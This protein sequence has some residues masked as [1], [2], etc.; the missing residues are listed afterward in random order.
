MT[1]F[2]PRRLATAL[3][4]ALTLVSC[5]TANN[6]ARAD[7]LRP[8][9]YPLVACDPYF[10]VWSFTDQLAE[11]F[12]VH[13][14]GQI[15][16]LTSFVRIDG[17]KLR[18]MGN[19]VEYYRS[20]RSMRQ[21]NVE[22]RATNTTYT[23]EEFGVE[24]KLQF[25]NPN[26]PDDLMIMS[27]PATYVTWTARSTDGANHEVKVYFDATAEL[28]VNTVD[29]KVVAKR[30]A[31]DNLDV[32]RLGTEAQETLVKSGDYMRVDYG[33]FY[34]AAEKGV[35]KNVIAGA[36]KARGVFLKSGDLP[37]A[38]DARFPRRAD[39]DWPVVAFT[40]DCG[41]VGK[42]AVSKRVIL[43]YDDVWA[44]TWLGEKIRPYWRKDGQNALG[45]L[46]EAN[47]QYDDLCKRCA[48]FDA[49]L[50][51]R[52][53]AKGGVK[54]AELCSLAYP[55]AIA[56]HKLAVMPNG[57]TILIS[58]ENSSNGC[59][60]TVDILYPTA[61]IFAATN[62]EL[63]KATTTPVL[64]Y[65]GKSGRW[66]H[67][68]A[69]HD[70]GQYPL[71]DGQRYGG[72]ERTEENQMPVEESA[73][74]IIIVDLIARIENSADYAAEYWDTLEKWAQYLLSKGLDPENQLCT[75]DFAGHLAHNANLSAKAIVALAC[76]SDLCQRAGKEDAAKEYRAKAEE[77]VKEWM[78]LADNG[79][80]YRLAFDRPDTWSMKYNIVW[81]R[82]MDLKLFPK[83]VVDKELAYYKKVQNKFG[84]PLDNR[85]DYT[86]TDWEVWVASMADTREGFDSVME[87]IYRS[88]NATPDRVPLTDWYYTSTAK[89]QAFRA[90]AVVGGIFM[91]LLEPDEK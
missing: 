83:E 68:F 54:Y 79:D 70:I 8:P 52:A 85:S 31:T 33:Y 2:S 10:S 21:T 49:S 57:K 5:A 40:L 26:L 72:G 46:E 42:D 7:E 3:A 34:V 48:D 84:I 87:P 55:Q 43:A 38:D 61:P 47:A 91:K 36:E 37:K 19:P 66:K 4:F 63:L 59:A 86:K 23:F 53:K 25:T 78:K 58:K 13:W 39:D 51:E 64:E 71:V 30:E 6:A 15:N 12:P 44:L 32:L 88:L 9:A 69:P 67:P 22:V 73:N 20:A 24:I 11:S 74:M 75:D 56:A 80:H 14:T 60:G 82:I 17:Q 29:Q 1:F 62:V 90:R 27:R 41:L 89:H 18:L 77:F 16:A 50:Y 45:M 35:S 28:C 81:D 65:A 76:F